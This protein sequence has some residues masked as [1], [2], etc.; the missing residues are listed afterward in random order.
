MTDFPG[1]PPEPDPPPP[2]ELRAALEAFPGPAVLLRPDYRIAAANGAYRRDYGDDAGRLES[3]CYAASH[4]YDLPCDLAG[5][6]CPLR[7][8]LEG[9]GRER[10]L[11]VHHTRRG[12][13]HV[14]VETVPI[15]NEAGEVVLVL[16]RLQPSP[17][18]GT[19]LPA[20][21]L[22]GR[23]RAFNRALELVHRVAPT[24]TAV[25]L[26]GE[27]GTGKELVARAVHEGSAQ[28]AG[29]FV[30]VECSGLTET[31]FESE[32]FGHE[33]GSFTGAVA[34]KPGLVESARGGTLFLDE[35]GDIPLSQQVKL[36]RLLET[37]TYRAV[38]S[39]E[40]RQ[41]DF[42]LV[43]ATNR[44]LR[45]LVDAGDFREDLFYR[46]SAFPV[47]L[48][49]LR[50]R[51]DDLALLVEHLLG[52]IAP[53][54]PLRLDGAVLALLAAYPFPGNI[55]ELRNVLEYSVLL[56]DDDVIRPGHLPDYLRADAQGAVAEGEGDAILPLEEVERR[57]LL[58][59]A[60]R[61]AGDRR[62]LARRLGVSER[63]LYRKL[64]ALRQR[65]AGPG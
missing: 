13:E 64:E 27:T 55:R 47:R 65:A 49:P 57:Y 10:V 44:D 33:R 51:V 23:S 43:C 48:P 3:R 62:E 37:G 29:P 34:R 25:L 52:R 2:A 63:T 41:A 61:F 15:T 1:P 26:L 17:V 8:T 18:A 50:E 45:A 54:R 38:G 19:D 30:P 58:R 53:G 21:G 24:R 5:E 6:S 31:L 60:S 4:H 39:V 16:E 36:L 56:A 59:V 7:G 20:A 35:V 40:P 28:P 46:I 14:E 42:R 9:G 22:V 11:H 12:E 32:L